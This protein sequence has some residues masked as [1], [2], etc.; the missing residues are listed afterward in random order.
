M[1]TKLFILIFLLATTSLSCSKDDDEKPDNSSDTEELIKGKWNL[2]SVHYDYFDSSNN[3]L[4]R[5]PEE[6]T[7]GTWEFDG[8]VVVIV[9]ADDGDVESST[10]TITQEGSDQYINFTT[11]SELERLRIISIDKNAMVLGD[12]FAPDTYVE[13]G[14]EKQAAKSSV[15][16]NFTR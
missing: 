15:R 12:D 1:K 2:N 7:Q 9:D 13:D 11:S 6:D 5:D 14:V 10:Y 16:A 3:L 4:F 8:R